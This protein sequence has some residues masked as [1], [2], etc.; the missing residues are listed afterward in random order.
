M[1]QPAAVSYAPAEC[2]WCSGTGRDRQTARPCPVC[3]SRGEVLAAQPPV[4]CRLCRGAGRD[5]APADGGR[6]AGCAGSGWE[7]FKPQEA[8]DAAR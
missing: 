7:A 4:T 8:R 5:G 2:A 6:C 3:R 1:S